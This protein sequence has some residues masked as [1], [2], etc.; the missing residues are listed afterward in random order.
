M[1][2]FMEW[3]MSLDY[4]DPDLVIGNPL[5]FREY[6]DKVMGYDDDDQ[7]EARWERQAVDRTADK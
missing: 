1:N 2:R 5:V 6:E 7:A 4:R 3:Q